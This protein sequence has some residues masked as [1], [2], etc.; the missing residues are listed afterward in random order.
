MAVA[1]A[2]M[3]SGMDV[4]VPCF[5]PHSR[6]DLVADRRPGLLRVQ[7]KTSRVLR[8]AVWFRTCSNTANRPRD[9]RDEIDAFGVFCPDRHEVYLVPVEDASVR[10]CS[11]RLEPP[12]NNQRVGIRWAAD[13]LVGSP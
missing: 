7:C 6:V 9:Y 3:R 5:A 4:Y 10:G 1:S 8:G 12:R 13:Y 2:L 11:L